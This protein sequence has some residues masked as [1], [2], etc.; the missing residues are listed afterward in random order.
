LKTHLFTRKSLKVVL[1]I[2]LGILSFSCKKTTESIGNG[3]L[4][5]GDLMGVYYTDTISID[6]YSTSIDS[7]LTKGMTSVLVGSIMDPVMG[8]TNASL[9]TQLHLSSTNQHFGDNP[10]V[11]S[12]VL[13]LAYNGYFGDT[14]TLQ[15]I[16]VY[17]LADSLSTVDNYY[18]FSDVEVLPTDLANGYQFYPKPKTTGTI[19]GIDTLTNPVL[20][21][22]L[23]N[24]FGEKLISADTSVYATPEDFKQYVYGLKICCE[25]VSEDGAILSFYPTSNTITVLQLYYHENPEAETRMRFNYY[26]TADD[27]YFNQYTHDYTLGSPE[28]VQQVVEG[29][30][31]LG[32]QQVYLQSM[33]G[34]RAMIRFP[35]LTE[36][37]APSEN[38]HIIINEAKLILPN[39]SL[40]PDSSVYQSISSLALLNINGDG[41]TSVL[42]DYFEGAN[43]YGGSYSSTKKQVMFR[44]SEHLQ[45]IVKGEQSNHGMYL[46]ITGASY[47]A[48]RWIIN[49]PASE[50]D[51]KLRCEIKYSIVGE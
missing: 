42:P 29:D 5:E 33:G 39:S 19:L 30:T 2:T 21:I 50:E 14:T 41:T 45:K 23:S 13:Q 20:R 28:F 27:V 47:N 34:V 46:S 37:K 51:E 49:G 9:L 7:M 17:E 8:L 32:Q 26:I 12:V 48:L 18:Q 15:T 6:C 44:I 16:H 40:L 36:W 1:L 4:S 43:Y 3:L 24:S 38:S 25:S 11:D 10:V 35:H 22:P 31:M